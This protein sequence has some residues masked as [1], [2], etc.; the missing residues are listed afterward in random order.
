MLFLATKPLAAVSYIGAMLSRATKSLAALFS[1]WRQCYLAEMYI[2]DV[3]VA[4]QRFLAKRKI[5]D[6]L[7][8]SDNVI[9]RHKSPCRFL[10]H[11]GS[12]VYPIRR[13]GVKSFPRPKRFRLA[14]HSK[15]R[16]HDPNK[17]YRRRQEKRRQPLKFSSRCNANTHSSNTTQ[18]AVSPVLSTQCADTN[19]TQRN[20]PSRQVLGVVYCNADKRLS[21]TPNRGFA[22][23]YAKDSRKAS[24]KDL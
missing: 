12:T 4:S 19:R 24:P 15:F 22:K 20:T 23:A 9:S 17:H 6:V 8:H 11:R 18:K 14:R 5:I 3:L 16:P 7:V 13:L 1:T 10:V 21:N 2:F